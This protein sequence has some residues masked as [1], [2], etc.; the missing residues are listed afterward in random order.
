MTRRAVSPRG[1]TVAIFKIATRGR[2]GLRQVDGP[3]GHPIVARPRMVTCHS[4]GSSGLRNSHHFANKVRDHF[5]VLVLLR[6]VAVWP[7]L[8]STTPVKTQRVRIITP[9]GCP[10]PADKSTTS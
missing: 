9:P 2:G 5:V 1:R 10:P 4:G 3:D 8:A 6:A 7:A